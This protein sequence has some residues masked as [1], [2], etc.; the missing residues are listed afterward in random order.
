MMYSWM[1]IPLP[2]TGGGARERG[3]D[4]ETLCP[5]LSRKRE[6]EKSD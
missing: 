4:L 5:S 1:L 2:L 6:R 3:R